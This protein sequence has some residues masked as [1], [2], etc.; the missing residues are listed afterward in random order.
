[1][2]KP[3]FVLNGPNLN[4]LG[5]REPAIYGSGDAGRYPR[6]ARRRAARRL[7]LTVDFRQSNSEGDAGRLDPGG[8]R[9]AQRHRHQC[10]RLHAH[11][12]CHPRRLERG[13]AAGDRGASVEYLP[14]RAVSPSSYVT[15][16]AHG[17]ICGFGPKG[18]ELAIEAMADLLE[19]RPSA[20]A[21]AAKGEPLSR[22]A[23][24]TRRLQKGP[25]KSWGRTSRPSRAV[26][27]ELIRELAQL[28]TETGLT[29]IEIERDGMRVRV[30]RSCRRAA[31]TVTAVGAPIGR[32]PASAQPAGASPSDPA[33]HPG[34]VQLADG[35]HGL[36]ARRSPAPPPFVERRQRASR[37][38]QTLLIIEAMKT[39][40]H[41]PAPQGRHGDADPG[42]QRPARRVRRAAGDHRIEQFSRSRHAPMFDKV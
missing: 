13:R 8:A 32:R 36:S 25:T 42:R 3:I 33:K 35:R 30:A 37:Q 11:L 40:N 18:Y 28:L 17:L 22:G 1:M 41:I 19:P 5:V 6:A 21:A 38:G 9:G 39:M 29:E 15:P 20:A 16:A 26:D 4:L 34:C 23:C 7:G 24:A 27:Q 12:D 31:A 2:P 14:A 10:R